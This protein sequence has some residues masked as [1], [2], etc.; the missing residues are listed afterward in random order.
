MKHEFENRQYI[1]AFDGIGQ[2]LSIH[3]FFVEE[4]SKEYINEKDF[5][6]PLITR[7]LYKMLCDFEGKIRKRSL[8]QY[9]NI[10][11]CSP[12]S[13]S[14]QKIIDDIKNNFTKEYERFLNYKVKRPVQ[15]VI[16]A[17][18]NVPEDIVKDMEIFINEINKTF[19]SAFTYADLLVKIGEKYTT[20]DLYSMN[21]N[22]T[23]TNNNLVI[24]LRN[25]N[26]ATE[27]KRALFTSVRAT[28]R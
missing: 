19:H 7:V 20:L 4:Y 12:L 24:N 27:G 18:L 21:K 28:L 16:N 14:S 6:T 9:C 25:D 11:C 26:F 10:D 5:G 13:K 1:E 23:R 22:F 3:D 15:H 2:V 17:W 8:V